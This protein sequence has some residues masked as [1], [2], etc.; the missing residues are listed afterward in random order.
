MSRKHKEQPKASVIVEAKA[1]NVDRTGLSQRGKDILAMLTA[2]ETEDKLSTWEEGFVGS[3]T[4][5]FLIQ[6][7]D[8]TPKQY[9]T[10]EKIYKKFN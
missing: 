6:Q 5:W 10:L 1:V 3:M 9:E 8:L 2:L 7:R 4:D